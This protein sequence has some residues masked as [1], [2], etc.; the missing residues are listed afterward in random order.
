MA[1]VV[2]NHFIVM[3]KDAAP[4]TLSLMDECGV[5]VPLLKMRWMDWHEN[6]MSFNHQE[7]GTNLPFFCHMS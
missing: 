1:K 6:C 7:N 3:G 4:A 2:I 5:G